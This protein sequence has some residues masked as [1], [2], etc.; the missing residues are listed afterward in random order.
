M[1]AQLFG[2]TI[3][4]PSNRNVVIHHVTILAPPDSPNTDGIDP[5]MQYNPVLLFLFWV[6]IYLWV[7]ISQM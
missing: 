7:I 2:P 4:F 6:L 3:E 1:V 5:G